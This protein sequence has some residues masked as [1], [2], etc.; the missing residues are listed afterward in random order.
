MIA[1]NQIVT[2]KR[3]L[4]IIEKGRLGPA[5]SPQLADPSQPMHA[6]AD[7]QGIGTVEFCEGGLEIFNDA[8]TGSTVLAHAAA[9]ALLTQSV[10]NKG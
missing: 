7:Q 8:G 9:R 2:P 1:V 5:P 3:G 10:P 4:Q 6:I